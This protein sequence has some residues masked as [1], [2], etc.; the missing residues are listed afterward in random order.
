MEN[1]KNLP[2]NTIL[3]DMR[4]TL[5]YTYLRLREQISQRMDKMSNFSTTALVTENGEDAY[6]VSELLD[7]GFSIEEIIDRFVRTDEIAIAAVRRQ[8][9]NMF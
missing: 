9:S 8:L 1:K 3:F 4:I 6:T 2:R 7:G 5:C